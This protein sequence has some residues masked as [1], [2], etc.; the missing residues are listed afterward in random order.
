VKNLHLLIYSQNYTLAES[1][2]KTLEETGRYRI[3]IEKKQVENYATKDKNDLHAL[4]FPKEREYHPKVSPVKNL[5]FFG[6]FMLDIS[7]R[8]LH[9]KKQHLFRLSYREVSILAELVENANHIV[10]R[11]FLL[12]NYWG[13]ISY[14]KSRCLDVLISKLRKYLSLDPSIEIVNYRSEGLQIVY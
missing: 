10:T 4:V 3:S 14:Y 1:V 9:W 6:E 8:K 5:V 13:E 2:K 7:Y 12:Y 11:N